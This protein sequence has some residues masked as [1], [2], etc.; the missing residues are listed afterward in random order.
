[1]GSGAQ[2]EACGWGLEWW[3]L[4]GHHEL[5]LKKG[6]RVPP[7]PY[8]EE[9]TDS[10]PERTVRAH[11]PHP[12]GHT[13]SK[14]RPRP[15]V[16]SEERPRKSSSREARGKPVVYTG[17]QAAYT[18]SQPGRPYSHPQE[19][20][21]RCCSAF[22]A[23]C[24]PARFPTPHAWP[25]PQFPRLSAQ[26]QDS[27]TGWSGLGGGISGLGNVP[28]PAPGDRTYL[29]PP[30]SPACPAHRLRLSRTPPLFNPG[31]TPTM[32]GRVGGSLP[33]VTRFT[34]PGGH[35]PLLAAACPPDPL[36]PPPTGAPSPAPS[37]G[38]PFPSQRLTP[39]TADRLPPPFLPCPPAPPPPANLLSIPLPRTRRPH[40]RLS[41]DAEAPPL[42]S[43][44]PP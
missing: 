39:N 20:A 7:L 40:S 2:W 21:E 26:P 29:S 34:L 16:F 11:H 1:M 32:P 22:K 19:V 13:E 25:E 9:E 18:C 41:Q 30:R 44:P 33:P 23:F 37:T 4:A 8:Q 12:P 24:S 43:P 42:S 6:Q 17:S 31:P 14:A 3:G 35:P 38:T 10:S 15:R 36:H 5:S 28:R 27:D